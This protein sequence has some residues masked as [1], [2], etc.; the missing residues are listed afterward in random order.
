MSSERISRTEELV[1]EIQIIS[2]SPPPSPT[3]TEFEAFPH[4]SNY[5]CGKEDQKNVPDNTLLVCIVGSG[6]A[7]P[8]I[9]QQRVS[10]D[11]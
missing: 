6:S 1:V 7:R 4:Y 3:T 8:T 11:N 9:Q 2:L 5:S 10:A